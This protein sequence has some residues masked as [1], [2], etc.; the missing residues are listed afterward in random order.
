[1]LLLRFKSVDN[2]TLRHL[3]SKLMVNSKMPLVLLQVTNLDQHLF[4]CSLQPLLRI[5]RKSDQVPT[6]KKYLKHSMSLKSRRLNCKPHWATRLNHKPRFT[7]SLM[8]NLNLTR[9]KAM[10]MVLSVSVI[11]SLA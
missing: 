7:T 10:A 5:T 2:Q 1:M 11:V 6:S 4:K 8:I 3:T 9:V